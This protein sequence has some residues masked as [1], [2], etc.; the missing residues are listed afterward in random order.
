MGRLYLPGCALRGPPTKCVLILLLLLIKA[1]QLPL[2]LL[3]LLLLIVLLL[4][5]MPLVLLSPAAIADP[6]AGGP[7]VHQA[8]RVHGDATQGGRERGGA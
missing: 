4:L 6:T 8:L 3:L 5:I 7:Q 1:L 2:P